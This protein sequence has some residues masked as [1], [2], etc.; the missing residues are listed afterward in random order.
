[1]ATPQLEPTQREVDVEQVRALE[2]EFQV[3]LDRGVSYA[4]EV[5]AIHQ[6]EAYTSLD[7]ASRKDFDR[8]VRT[9]LPPTTAAAREDPLAGLKKSRQYVKEQRFLE[10]ADRLEN[11]QYFYM[12]DHLTGRN[13]NCINLDDILHAAINDDGP[14]GLQPLARDL[15]EN[16][17]LFS[18]LDT[19]GNG[20][21]SAEELRAG[22]AALRKSIADQEAQALHPGAAPAASSGAAPPPPP[23][24]GA[25]AQD[26]SSSGLSNLDLARAPIT[27][28]MGDVK[29]GDPLGM[30][31][32]RLTNA[33][34]DLESQMD[35]VVARMANSTDDKEQ[36]LLE[37]RLNKL[38][39]AMTS[40]SNMLQ[41]LLT[42]RE[43]LQKM[44]NDI[45]MRAISH[46]V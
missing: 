17:G 9:E 39:R 37:A 8:W 26:G 20:E 43:N 5:A 41:Q 6:L 18:F 42:M 15:L 3:G 22:I 12:M 45:A 29:A 30:A 28:H 2:R 25:G 21:I 24:S 10:L 14:P 16:P 11:E 36:K 38:N 27:L 34:G 7:D 19:S 23:S 31:T 1:M 32:E 40:V 35:D 4:D 46:I 13:D 44:F 33:M